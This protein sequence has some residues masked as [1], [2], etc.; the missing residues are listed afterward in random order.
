MAPVRLAGVEI[1]YSGS[2]TD[3]EGNAA[4]YTDA[5]MSD[6]EENFRVLSSG[7]RPV[8]NP[9]VGVGHDSGPQGD[10]IFEWD[11]TLAAGQV[12]GVKTRDAEVGGETRR[13]L[14]ADLEVTD[15]V[16]Q[17]VQDGKLTRVSAE[18][19]DDP[20]AEGEHL[21]ARGKTLRRVALLGFAP[22]SL[23]LL[24]PLPM[25]EPLSASYGERLLR[26]SRLRRLSTSDGR[27]AE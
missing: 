12:V 8:L 22:P 27:R 17:W 2:H 3:S 23:K 18:M 5:D 19:W 9:P 15:E 10:D 1:F 13:V 14:V 11:T 16:G 7:E 21:G 25:P 26:K 4:T 24:K 20:P 6:A